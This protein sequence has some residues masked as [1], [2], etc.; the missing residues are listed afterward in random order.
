MFDEECK[1]EDNRWK[2]KDK[3]IKNK[4]RKKR[5]CVEIKLD[6]IEENFKNNEGVI[7]FRKLG[8]QDNCI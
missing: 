4:C 8:E 5:Q 2:R 6:K 1:T 7:F 3:L